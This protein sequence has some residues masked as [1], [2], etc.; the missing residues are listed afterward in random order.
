M[1]P[2][3]EMRLLSPHTQSD[4]GSRVETPIE[5]NISIT[6]SMPDPFTK[7]AGQNSIDSQ[8]DVFLRPKDD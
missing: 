7:A 8:E 2:V 6:L 1:P 4:D 3:N 5:G